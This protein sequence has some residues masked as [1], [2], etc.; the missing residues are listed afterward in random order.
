MC[1]MSFDI[2]KGMNG[3][4]ERKRRSE[5]KREKK[6]KMKNDII[7]R[8]YH[9]LLRI[10]KDR[11]QRMKY[12][13]RRA[14]IWINNSLSIEYPGV[15]KQSVRSNFFPFNL[16]TLRAACIENSIYFQG[17]FRNI[18]PSG[19]ESNISVQVDKWF[20][21]GAIDILDIIKIGFHILNPIEKLMAKYQ[22]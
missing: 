17:K 11:K 18:L 21:M 8:Q 22:I 6:D 3:E 14:Y 7:G 10:E 16:A 2:L 5:K 1:C 4:W 15:A 9:Y 19:S 12:N 20:F 13:V